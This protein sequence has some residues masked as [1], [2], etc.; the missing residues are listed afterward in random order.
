MEW[1]PRSGLSRT[2]PEVDRAGW[3][4][5]EAARRKILE[6]QLPLLEQLARALE[7]QS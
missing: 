5:F 3:F 6:G 4:S 7:G 1:P 2:F